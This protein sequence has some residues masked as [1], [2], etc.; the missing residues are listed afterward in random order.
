MLEHTFLIQPVLREIQRQSEL[1][2]LDIR[3]II[4]KELRRFA[5]HLIPIV[6]GIDIDI[7]L[8]VCT[9]SV[10]NH[11]VHE[12]TACCDP[13]G[14]DP[15]S[16]PCFLGGIPLG[17]SGKGLFRLTGFKS[18]TLRHR[19]DVSS[20]FH[21]KECREG[22]HLI[23]EG[24]TQTAG[25]FPL[26]IT[27]H[28]ILGCKS[29]QTGSSIN[30]DASVGIPGE[31]RAANGAILFSLSSGNIDVAPCSF[32]QLQF[33]SSGCKREHLV[34]ILRPVDIQIPGEILYLHQTRTE[35]NLKTLVEDLAG[36]DHAIV[37][38]G[39]RRGSHTDDLVT[40]NL[41]VE[42]EVKAD[43]VVRPF[44][45][46]SCFPRAC[47]CRFEVCVRDDVPVDRADGI[48]GIAE[49]RLAIPQREL[50]RVC[51]ATYLRP[52]ES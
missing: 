34:I 45:F 48:T 35:C 4:D 9:V 26:C 29:R 20:D 37:I 39:G 25:P 46:K 11:A 14:G 47:T 8:A 6:L 23:T 30:D 49:L 24:G 1:A 27:E 42:R 10:I 7:V 12:I 16:L 43:T 2:A 31:C 51:I 15:C 40:G 38:A 41:V 5:G 3:V 50:V 17:T 18:G 19:E 22:D 52:A 28:F 21:I 33:G 13:S 44:G 36:V 32:G